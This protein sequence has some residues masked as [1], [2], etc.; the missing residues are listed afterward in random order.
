[1]DL[2]EIRSELHKLSELVDGW[3]E[4]QSVAALERDWALEKLRAIYEVLR[5]GAGQTAAA[6]AA[7]AAAPAAT[8]AATA[9]PEEPQPEVA[10]P[11]KTP[12]PVAAD[13]GEVLSSEPVEESA[14]IEPVAPGIVE[15][16]VERPV[17]AEA[18]AAPTAGRRIEVETDPAL[19]VIDLVDEPEEVPTTA[20]ASEPEHGAVPS[21]EPD[22]EPENVSA[23]V[24]QSVEAEPQYADDPAQTVEMEPISGASSEPELPEPEA[25]TL[26][27]PDDEKE[28][29]R[30]KQRVIMSLYDTT[31]AEDVSVAGA[32]HV[33]ESAVQ[34]HPTPA[35]RRKAAAGAEPEIVLLDA[36]TEEPVEESRSK[37]AARS[38][39]PPMQAPVADP[40]VPAVGIYDSA[41][42][43]GDFDSEQVPLDIEVLQ[44]DFAAPAGAVLGE[45]IN[46]DVQT[47]AD[48]IAAPGFG[49]YGE[50]ISD[51][52][53]AIGINDKFLMI[54]DLF[55]GD[56]ALF[57][58]TI[59][60]LNAQPGLDDCMIYIAEHFAWNPDSESARLMMELLERKFA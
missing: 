57:E 20:P 32:E 42:P 29:H 28:L 30:R 12:V 48:T 2:K 44:E 43:Q 1:M 49:R 40:E 27:G 6:A 16:S 55:G 39:E 52:R 58:T 38:I 26:F 18:P 14:E 4:L 53:Q 35:G 17:H 34:Q 23:S 8:E 13:S 15:L 24:P 56:S 46:H 31:P 36:Y 21:D 59:A 22:T 45:V 60:A 33:E 51:L 41:E 11:T 50:P 5:F 54:R 19:E 47:L 37:Q 9:V 7:A 3:Q 25:P 10:A